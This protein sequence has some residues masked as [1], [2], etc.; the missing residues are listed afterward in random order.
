MLRIASLFWLCFAMISVGCS[1]E[2]S[3]TAPSTRAT[4][5]SGSTSNNDTSKN[6]NSGD[7]ENEDED[8]EVALI[9]ESQARSTME[10]SCMAAAC[11]ADIDTIFDAE[12]TLTRIENETMPPPDQARYTLSDRKRAELVKFYKDKE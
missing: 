4:P 9:S 2:S 12:T 3:S 7:D 6:T 1:S 8:E 10:A 11:H 5:D